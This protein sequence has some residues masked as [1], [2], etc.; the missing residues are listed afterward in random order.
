M[1]LIKTFSSYT[2]INVF[3]T[4]IPYLLLPVLTNYLTD[5]DYG[6]L[7]NIQALFFLFVPLVGINVAAAVGREYFKEEVQLNQY[8]GTSLA[9][10]FIAFA[11]IQL[12]TFVF[13]HQLSSLTQ[14]PYT[15]NLR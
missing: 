6:I 9:I 5:S 12:I 11:L 2:L 3:S 4:A 1:S 7:S 10:S 15:S 14:I 13:G 8:T